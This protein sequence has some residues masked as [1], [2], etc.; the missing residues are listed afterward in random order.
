MVEDLT[1][2]LLCEVC[3]I[4][5]GNELGANK[6]LC[7]SVSDDFLEEVEAIGVNPGQG[8]QLLLVPEMEDAFV[9]PD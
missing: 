7:F 1:V 3:P 9:L 5:L 6:G 8:S 2:P 4:G